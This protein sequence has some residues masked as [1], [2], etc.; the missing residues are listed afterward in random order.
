[1]KCRCGAHLPVA[2]PAG[3]PPPGRRNI[4]RPASLTVGRRAGRAQRIHGRCAPG[5]QQ[6][7]RRWSGHRRQ[8]SAELDPLPHLERFACTVEALAQ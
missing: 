4:Y 7:P 6:L 2:A 3:S 5:P 8:R 1:M